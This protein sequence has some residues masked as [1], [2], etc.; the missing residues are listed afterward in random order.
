M[1]VADDQVQ[2]LIGELHKCTEPDVLNED[3][4]QALLKTCKE[5]QYQLESPRETANRLH[6]AASTFAYSNAGMDLAVAHIFNSIK[7][8]HVLAKHKEAPITTDEI[9]KETNADPELLGRLLRY[10]AS[11]GFVAQT[12][13]GTWSPSHITHSLALPSSEANVT[14]AFICEFPF[15]IDL[16]TFLSHTHYKNPLDSTHTVA[17]FAHKTDKHWFEWATKERPQQFE[18]LNQYMATNLHAQT[19]IDVFPFD[20]ILPGLFGAERSTILNPDQ[21]LFTDIGGGRGQIC[22]AFKSRYPTLPGRIIVQDLPLTL[23]GVTPPSGIE[24]LHHDFFQPQP[25]KGA[26]IY[27]LRHV[28]HDWPDSICETILKNIIDA[29][30]DESILLVDDKVLPDV[31]AST[32]ASALDLGMMMCF[33]AMER[34]E[35]QWK[36]LMGKVGMKV[37]R[38]WRYTEDVGDSVLLVKKGRGD[39]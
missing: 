4:R 20:T 19:G 15:L 23:A 38:I 16:P 8:F 24:A 11:V 5:L 30:D 33:A 31:G 6:Y 10:A 21:V 29:M 1:T 32:V 36:S 3:S 35:S 18:A 9:A 34:T 12:K 25:I 28:L 14:E 13:P 22:E 39:V 27:Y 37:E 2:I 7:L 26:K 17:Q